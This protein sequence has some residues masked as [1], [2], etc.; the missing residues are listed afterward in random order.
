MSERIPDSRPGLL[1]IRVFVTRHDDPARGSART[2]AD[3]PCTFGEAQQVF[4]RWRGNNTWVKGG[5]NSPLFA[6][7][8]VG[9]VS[10]A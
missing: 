8:L 9:S 4:E 7:F 1:V 10:I 5:Y 3:I 2:L 6:D